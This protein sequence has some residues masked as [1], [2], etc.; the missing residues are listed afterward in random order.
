[1]RVFLSYIGEFANIQAENA[2]IQTK[3]NTY[4]EKPTDPNIHKLD[5]K[6]LADEKSKVYITY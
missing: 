2:N 3:K 1:M 6:I 4:T 5:S